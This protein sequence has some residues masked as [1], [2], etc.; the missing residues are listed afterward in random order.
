M[1]RGPSHSQFTLKCVHRPSYVRR[2]DI[3][4]GEADAVIGLPKDVWDSLS[5]DARNDGKEDQANLRTVCIRSTRPFRA[6]TNDVPSADREGRVSSG[7]VTSVP[8]LISYA[9]L[10]TSLASDSDVASVPAHFTLEHPQIFSGDQ[11]DLT[12]SMTGISPPRLTH[13]FLSAL[14]HEAYGLAQRDP[15]QVEAWFCEDKEGGANPIVR[16]GDTYTFEDGRLAN[17]FTGLERSHQEARHGSSYAV[18]MTEP[19]LQGVA[20]LGFTA[21]VISPGPFDLLPHQNGHRIVEPLS[22]SE[23]ELLS[24]DE[25]SIDESFLARST[26]ASMLSSF[27]VNGTTNDTPTGTGAHKLFQISPLTRRSPEDEE[28]D[29][30]NIYV[31]TQDL[32][33]IG[34]FSGDW[35]VISTLNSEGTSSNAR[36]ARVLAADTWL[37][38]TSS[39]SRALASPI[40]AH[41]LRLPASNAQV[42]IVPT[43]FASLLP[44]IPTA[45]T[46]TLARIASPIANNKRMQ[47]A[48]VRGLRAHFAGRKVLVKRDD[49]IGV[50]VLLSLSGEVADEGEDVNNGDS[51]EDGKE[52]GQDESFASPAIGA[53]AIVFFKVTHLEHPVID[54]TNSTSDGTNDG[55]FDAYVAATMGELG[56][57]VDST[58]TKM[59]QAGVEHSLIPSNVQ[60]YYNIS[61]GMPSPPPPGVSTAIT[62]YEKLYEIVSTCLLPSAADYA[63][64]ISILLKGAR[65]TGKRT[66]VQWVAEQLGVHAFEINCYEVVGESPA[67]TEGTLRARF[68]Q[69]AAC[70]PCI[71][72]LSHIEALARKSQELESGREPPILPA[73]QEC[74]DDLRKAWR[75]TG[76]PIILVATT[77][78]AEHLPIG[79]LGCFKHE[80]AFEA[81]NEQER[82]AILQN[83]LYSMDERGPKLP[84]APD[85]ALSSIATQTAALVASD[86]VD[87]VSRTKMAAMGR[88][89]SAVSVKSASEEH[90]V[91][92]ADIISAGVQLTSADF[93]VAL[94]DARTTYSESIGAPKIPNVSWD[95]VGGLGSVKRD[96]LDTIQLPLEHPELF[97]DGLKKRSGILLY[98][99]PGTGKTLL[100]KAVATS[101]SLNFFSVKGPELL[102]MYI[103]ESEANVRRV[104]QR[105]RDAK[106]CV[107]FFDELDSVAPK[108]GN[109]GDSGGV[110]DR[111]VS[112]LLAELDGMADGGSGG[113]VFVIGATNRPDLLDSALLRPGRFDRML[114]LGVSDTHEAQ[115]RIIKALTRKFRLDPALDLRNVA[116]K[117]P[118]NYT[119][120]DFYALCS[121]AML[122]AMTRKAEDIEATIATLNDQP[123]PHVHP[124][125]ITPQYYLAEMA[126]DA[127]TDV[128]VSQADFDAALHELV[129]SVSASEME[130]YALVQQKFAKDTI[131]S[132]AV[133]SSPAEDRKGKGKAREVD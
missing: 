72:L 59:V 15:K 102:N 82:L 17:G 96:I 104:F 4:T 55:I 103:G 52:T 93:E 70:S 10:D 123:P 97:A 5:Q 130:H 22:D 23:T 108:R 37:P 73:I 127:E 65:G 125:P 83:V 54:T 18:L 53:R 118:F 34:T 101:C 47:D 19:V 87:L 132:V 106:P 29:L 11:P 43:P 105:A 63:L 62:P 58:M 64:H 44:P 42:H 26:S 14:S 61:N 8:S 2:V 45:T 31:R 48:V 51:E 36:L 115:Y 60:S 80:I 133:A 7:E 71:F 116:E 89:L 28:E 21:F 40:V 66:A 117:C 86:L 94:G 76:Y 85:I 27:K 121:D 32:S 50:P 129:P 38:K 16:Q 113:D 78:D 46:I 81:P 91:T 20:V 77:S 69:A 95:D 74:L 33:K 56:C 49:L 131:N 75:E 100:A 41:N 119:G 25:L 88:A 84:I 92:E 57:Y 9:N 120:A 112:Q 68:E 6:R 128:L 126:S 124:H 122:K 30:D 24:E 107:I 114:Y 110:M 79:I 35:A 3:A 1:S 13:I 67:K 109:H 98:G 99:P 39:T 12:I 90:V 111:I